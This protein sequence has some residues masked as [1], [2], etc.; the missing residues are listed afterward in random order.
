[1]RLEKNIALNLMYWS[2]GH[3]Y[4]SPQVWLEF[5]SHKLFFTIHQKKRNIAFN[6]QKT[7]PTKKQIVE[8]IDDINEQITLLTKTMKKFSK[9]RIKSDAWGTNNR[10]MKAHIKEES[11]P[12][13]KKT[14]QCY[15]CKDLISFN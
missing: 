8:A 7:F 4:L 12:L 13:K 15:E 5:E 14:V 6:V 3:K 11:L 9:K 2:D 10:D 1:M